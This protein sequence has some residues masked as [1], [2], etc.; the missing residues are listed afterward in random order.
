MIDKTVG[1]TEL[2]WMVFIVILI[3][4]IAFAIQLDYYLLCPADKKRLWYL[5]LL[6]LFFIYNTVLLFHLS[7]VF[8][9]NG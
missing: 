3:E 6:V 4:A 8:L 2:T 7:C 5:L 9:L 1:N